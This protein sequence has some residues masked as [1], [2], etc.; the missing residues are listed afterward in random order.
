MLFIMV[1]IMVFEVPYFESILK[2]GQNEYN[3]KE[4]ERFGALFK[5]YPRREKN[6]PRKGASQCSLWPLQ[7]VKGKCIL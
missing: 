6:C 1:S 5:K 2:G 4:K 3:C 7:Q